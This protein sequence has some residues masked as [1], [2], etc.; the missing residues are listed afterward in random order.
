MREK[1]RKSIA[2]IGKFPQFTIMNVINGQAGLVIYSSLIFYSLTIDNILNIIVLLIL[3]GITIASLSGENGI[4][5]RAKEARDETEIATIEEQ[6]ELAKMSSLDDNGEIIKQTLKSELEKIEGIDNIIDKVNGVQVEYKEKSQFIPTGN[7]KIEL[8]EDELEDIAD[9]IIEGQ[10]EQDYV[11]GIDVYGNQVD[12]SNWDY[13]FY[14]ADL[15]LMYTGNIEN[16][17]II[18]EIPAYIIKSESGVVTKGA[19]TVL[20]GTFMNKTDLKT[21]N[22][23][24]PKTITY[25]SGIFA[26]SGITSIPPKINMDKAQSTYGMFQNCT[27]LTE[28]PQSFNLANASSLASCQSMFEGCTNLTTIPEGFALPSSVTTTESMFYGTKITKIPQSL[29]LANVTGL[30]NCRNMF[31]NCTGLTEIPQS[32]NLANASS[33]TSC[34]S[35]FEGCTNLTTIEEGFALPTSVANTSYM[36]QNTKITK[37]PDSLNFKNLNNLQSCIAT[38][39]N[40]NLEELPAE[41]ELGPNVTQ[42]T[43][44]FGYTKLKSLPDGLNLKNYTKLNDCAWAFSGSNLQELSP[45]FGLPDS[46]INCRGLFAHCKQ[47]K[48]IPDSFNLGSN[49]EVCDRLFLS[50]NELTNFPVNFTIPSKV[51]NLYRMFEGCYKIIGSVTIEGTPGEQELDGEIIS[52]YEKAFEDTAQGS[53]QNFTVYYPSTWSQEIVDGIKA[54]VESGKV[55]FIAK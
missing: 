34:Q 54:T 44:M 10:E 50:C 28:I 27:G 32:L 8:G 29:N 35:M 43:S 33:L 16:E 4:L 25:Y 17:T 52:G 24:F 37:I 51:T 42:I 46:V 30:I 48:E 21:I 40:T 6:I 11:I 19:V 45:D 31:Q 2:S 13:R 1:N 18:G 22:V 5:T 41:F 12:L 15:L 9:D 38:F 26:N 55:T 47:L 23:A 20:E 3:A 39:L 36:F 49:V 53:A 7:G 14:N